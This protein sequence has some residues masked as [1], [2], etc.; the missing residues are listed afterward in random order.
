MKKENNTEITIKKIP[1]KPLLDILQ[2]V[3]EKGA[4][5]VDIIGVTGDV[6]NNVLIAI[7]DDYMNSE[8]EEEQSPKKETPDGG[9]DEDSLTDDQLNLL[10]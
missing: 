5:Y 3:W 10:L 9:D 6:Q 8:E 7:R 1:L 4:D 2:D